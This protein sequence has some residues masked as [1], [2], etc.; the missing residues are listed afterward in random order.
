MLTPSKL[1]ALDCVLKLVCCLCDSERPCHSSRCGC[2]AA[3]S[4]CAAFC[5][6][7]GSSRAIGEFDEADKS[8]IFGFYYSVNTL[9]IDDKIIKS[10]CH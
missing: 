6:C 1:P 2:V 7:Q 4:T 3:N 9:N 10:V 5:H 8:L